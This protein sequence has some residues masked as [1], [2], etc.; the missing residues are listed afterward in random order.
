MNDDM[1]YLCNFLS[2]LPIEDHH[3]FGYR[4]QWDH[5]MELSIL[6]VDHTSRLNS[7]G[8][9]ILIITQIIGNF[10]VFFKKWVGR[11]KNTRMWYMQL[12]H[13]WYIIPKCR[14]RSIS[15]NR[16]TLWIMY[17]KSKNKWEIAT[18]AYIISDITENT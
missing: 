7:V 11:I 17:F 1:N 14:F 5:P 16:L 13:W 10:N 2:Y 4:H 8:I 12:N 6:Y 3:S 15:S 18:Y 9:V